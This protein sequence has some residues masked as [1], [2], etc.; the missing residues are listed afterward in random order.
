MKKFIGEWSMFEKIWLV[1]F[2]GVILYLS[3]VWQDSLIGIISSLT[4]ML[5]VVLV[6]KGKISNYYF[7]I[8]NVVL[9]SYLS[10]NQGF[11]GVFMLNAFYFLPMQFVGIW[12]WK[13][14]AAQE[15]QFDIKISDMSN[16]TKVKWSVIT[17]LSIVG[18]AY[19]LM[20]LKGNLPLVDSITTV[21]QV[22]AMWF[23][24]KCFK[25][26]W[27]LWIVVNIV[28]IG[29]WLYAFTTTGNDVSVLI[30][31]V[32]YLVNSVYGYVKWHKESKEEVQL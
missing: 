8:I 32:A 7:G 4:G 15:Q 10:F 18:Y 21:L 29:M 12:M 25:E 23:M 11:Y 26:Q 3:Y 17:V 13:R 14:K 27:L 6:A 31:W 9:F 19:V 20:L 22:L 24:V 16:K 28:S 1:A 5:C 30:M 2:T